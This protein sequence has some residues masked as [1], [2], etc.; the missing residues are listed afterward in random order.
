LIKFNPTNDPVEF[1]NQRKQLEQI[2]IPE[3]QGKLAIQAAG[4]NL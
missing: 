4:D 1:E 2:M 3:L